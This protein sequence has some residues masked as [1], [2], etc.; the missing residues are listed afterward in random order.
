MYINIYKILILQEKLTQKHTKK[1]K[2]PPCCSR[3]I[4]LPLLPVALPS[5][6]GSRASGENWATDTRQK[7]HLYLRG[8]L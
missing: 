8:I 5:A 4:I 3:T 7:Q 6:V 1:K 2:S